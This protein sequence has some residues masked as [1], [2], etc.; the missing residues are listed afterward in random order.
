MLVQTHTNT[1]TQRN[2]ER[3]LFLVELVACLTSGLL[4]VLAAVPA[5]LSPVPQSAAPLFSKIHLELNTQEQSSL[6]F[7]LPLKAISTT[8]SVCMHVCQ[9][10]KESKTVLLTRQI[11]STFFFFSFLFP[12]CVIFTSIRHLRRHGMDY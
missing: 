11:I 4:S 10:K 7:N 1:H 8:H 12:K 5:C 2:R 3:G 9:E 6:S